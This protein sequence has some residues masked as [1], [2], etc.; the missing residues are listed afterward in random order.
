VE[1]LQVSKIKHGRVQDLRMFLYIV[2]VDL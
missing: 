2:L 1:V